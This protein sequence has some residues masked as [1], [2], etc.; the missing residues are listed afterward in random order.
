MLPCKVERLSLAYQGKTTNC[1]SFKITAKRYL[2]HRIWTEK[3]GQVNLLLVLKP[4][5]SSNV[6]ERGRAEQQKHMDDVQ[7]KYET[8]V[9][10]GER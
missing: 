3:V 8:L 5:V 4:R 7:I 1:E 2:F 9:G 10:R 6:K